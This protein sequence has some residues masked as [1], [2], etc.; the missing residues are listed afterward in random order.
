VF[1]Y[2]ILI[3]KMAKI[4]RALYNNNLVVLRGEL[5]ENAEAD[6]IFYFYRDIDEGEII[7]MVTAEILENGKTM[8]KVRELLEEVKKKNKKLIDEID[9]DYDNYIAYNLFGYLLFIKMAL[10]ELQ[11]IAYSRG[12]TKIAYIIAKN[13]ENIAYEFSQYLLKEWDYDKGL[14]D[15]V[16]DIVNDKNKFIEYYEKV[17]EKLNK[18]KID[19]IDIEEAYDDLKESFKNN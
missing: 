18:G 6:V 11:N 10:R 14:E 9:L 16:L 15:D 13:E 8:I 19:K 7:K 2:Y 3:D 12:L 17:K 1:F 5:D 4:V